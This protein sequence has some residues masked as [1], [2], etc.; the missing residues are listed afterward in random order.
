MEYVICGG[1][2]FYSYS[3]LTL[4]STPAR[5]ISVAIRLI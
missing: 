4:N 3:L 5:K 1:A 2:E